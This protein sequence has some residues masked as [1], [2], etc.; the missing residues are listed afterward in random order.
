MIKPEKVE[1]GALYIYSQSNNTIQ[2]PRFPITIT[3]DFH[4]PFTQAQV[5][6][7]RHNFIGAVRRSVLQIFV[8]PENN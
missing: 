7:K 3:N 5:A 8:H 6:P 1:G 4:S 2:N